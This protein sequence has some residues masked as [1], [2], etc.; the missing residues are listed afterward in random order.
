MLPA[1]TAGLGGAPPIVPEISAAFVAAF[2]PGLRS[3]LVISRKAALMVRNACAAL[4]GDLTLLA[5][6]HGSKSAF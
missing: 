6:V 3:K 4:S 2:L 1:L 5:F